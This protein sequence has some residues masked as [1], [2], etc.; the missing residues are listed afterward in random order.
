MSKVR[1]FGL[2]NRKLTAGRPELH[3]F[4]CT[5]CGSSMLEL[6]LWVPPN[7][8]LPLLTLSDYF[9]K[10]VEAVPLPTK[11]AYGVAK[12]LLKVILLDHYCTFRFWV[13]QDC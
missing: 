2:V 6:I 13:Y 1:F 9:T 11:E 5:P 7:L 8:H 10:W 3:L 4:L 12:V